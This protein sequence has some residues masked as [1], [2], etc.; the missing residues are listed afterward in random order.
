MVAIIS[1]ICELFVKPK[2]WNVNKYDDNTTWKGGHQY[3]LKGPDLRVRI[4]IAID[5]FKEQKGAVNID[6]SCS[7]V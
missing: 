2:L 3:N 6:C 5:N 4:T 1:V 7:C